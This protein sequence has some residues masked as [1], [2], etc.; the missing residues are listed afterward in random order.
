MP[1]HSKGLTGK[2]TTVLVCG[3]RN[4]FQPAVQITTSLAP[5]ALSIFATQNSE[6]IE[7][8]NGAATRRR[9]H[10]CGIEYIRTDRAGFSGP[11]FGSHWCGFFIDLARNLTPYSQ[12]ALPIF[13]EIC[14]NDSCRRFSRLRT[15]KATRPQIKPRP[16]SLRRSRPTCS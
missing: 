4:V 1:L 3:N 14:H 11:T 10:H 15:N 16:P 2:L 5:L 12:K 8:C 13:S 6:H 7:W 9:E